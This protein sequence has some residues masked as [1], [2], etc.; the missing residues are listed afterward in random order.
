VANLAVPVPRTYVVGEVETAA[1]YNASVRDAVNFLIGL[2]IATVYQTVAQPLTSG[3]PAPISFD[4]S[5]VDTYGGHSGTV[6]PSRYT[7]QV[8]GWYLIG[9]A[10]PM[11]NATAGTYRKIQLYYNGT[12]IAY[13]TS[14]IPSPSASATAVVPALSPTIVYMNVGDFVS[15][16]AS[17]DGSGVSITPNSSNQAYM[18]VVWAHS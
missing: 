4:S 8:A 12:A 13:A 15:I 6:N 1:Y 2:P 16:Y 11:A 17:V 14:Q 7:A 18:T 3:T 9:G 5:A 10:A